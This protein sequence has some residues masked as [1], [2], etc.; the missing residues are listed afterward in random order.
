MIAKHLAI[1]LLLTASW[2]VGA[3]PA[4]NPTGMFEPGLIS[5][6][7]VFGLTISPDG[8]HALWVR[9]GGKREQ[10]I[11]MQS[12][13]VNGHWQKPSPVSFSTNPA[14]KDIDPAF[15]PDGKTVIFQSNRPVPG[16][17]G[18]KGFDIWSVEYSSGTWGEPVHLGEQIN[19]DESESSA[20]MASNGTIYF[21]KA[22]GDN[23][24]DLWLSKRV[25]GKYQ[26]PE[27]LGSPINTAERE[28]NPYIAPDESYLIY[29]SSDK[30][31]LGDVDL[32]ISFRDNGKWTTPRHIDAPINS[33]AGEFCPWVHGDRIYFSRQVAQGGRFVE[34]IYSFLFNP[35]DYRA[36]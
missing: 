19:T 36:R 33:S 18:R 14:W 21:M 30:R 20:S 6:G 29:F 32:F 7:G 15:S 2:S 22:N 8:R 5:D 26:A 4:L 28:S 11:I 17:P 3:A 13:K 24:S 1:A 27:N 31:G 35:N 9:S 23:N 34:D 10:L 16:K 12:F 25:D